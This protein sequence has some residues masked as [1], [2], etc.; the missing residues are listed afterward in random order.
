MNAILKECI[1][2]VPEETRR[3]VDLSEMIAER[4]DAAMKRQGITNA[5]LARKMGKSRS[6]VGK[7]LTGRNNFTLETIAKIETTLGERLITP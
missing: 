4:L 2:A 3:Y 1:A 7:W 5:A 6:E